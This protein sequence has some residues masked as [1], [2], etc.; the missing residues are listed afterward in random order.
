[1]YVT[2]C[3]GM[4]MVWAVMCHMMPCFIMVNKRSLLFQLGS[5]LPLIAFFSCVPKNLGAHKRPSWDS[6]VQRPQLSIW[7]LCKT[8]CDT[9]TNMN[10]HAC[11]LCSHAH[12]SACFI[13]RLRLK[14]QTSCGSRQTTLS[15]TSLISCSP[16]SLHLYFLLSLWSTHQTWATKRKKK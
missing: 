2:K 13:M 12:T 16:T 14:T 6:S 4:K 11:T 5:S 3:E 9:C 1:M 7:L 15:H 8:K 10:T